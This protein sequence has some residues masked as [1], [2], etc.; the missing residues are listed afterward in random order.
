MVEDLGRA[1]YFTPADLA[2]N[3]RGAL[4]PDQL[5]GMLAQRESLEQGRRTMRVLMPAVAAAML[6][7]GLAVVV[8]GATAQPEL[9]GGGFMLSMCA[10]GSYW[11]FTPR[12]GAEPPPLSTEVHTATGKP[13]LL[14]RWSDYGDVWPTRTVLVDGLCF[15]VS[16]AVWR[17]MNDGS[18]YRLYYVEYADG[19]FAPWLPLHRGPHLLA[20]EPWPASSRGGVA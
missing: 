11:A 4:G 16:D 13:K 2:A 5:R 18:E 9:M 20:A 12:R 14:R 10:L 6:L 8:I 15:R 19:F 7:G 1:L 17:A 3:R